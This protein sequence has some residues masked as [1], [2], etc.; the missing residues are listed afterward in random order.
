MHRCTCD[1]CITAPAF[2]EAEDIDDDLDFEEADYA[3]P[4]CGEECYYDDGDR[5]VDGCWVCPNCI[6]VPIEE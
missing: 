3:C 5:H 1:V 6:D 2:P 4:H